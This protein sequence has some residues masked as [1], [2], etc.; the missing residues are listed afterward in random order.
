MLI[1]RAELAGASP[2]PDHSTML[3]PG[4]DVDLTALAA[5]NDFDRDFINAMIPHHQS[6]I[7]MS[8]AAM[9]NLKKQ[10]VRDL[11]HDITVTQQVEIVRMK[12]WLKDWYR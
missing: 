2:T 10:E 6:A 5:S 1:W 7:D 4:M 3:M 9:P 12:R 8:N 11:A